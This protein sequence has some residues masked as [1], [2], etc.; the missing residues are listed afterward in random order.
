MRRSLRRSMDATA[1]SQPPHP[2]TT[3]TDN[4]RLWHLSRAG[5]VWLDGGW[6]KLNP[7]SCFETQVSQGGIG[8]RGKPDESQPR[9]GSGLDDLQSPPPQGLVIVRLHRAAPLSV[10][11]LRRGCQCEWRRAC[12]MVK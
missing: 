1:R 12:T 9:S 3:E 7:G 8:E 2:Q 10:T 4:T 5:E 11:D 6:Q